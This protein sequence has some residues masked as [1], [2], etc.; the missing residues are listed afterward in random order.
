MRVASG[1][2]LLARGKRAS[3]QPAPALLDAGAHIVGLHVTQHSRLDPAVGEIHALL[4]VR[5]PILGIAVAVLHLGERKLHCLRIAVLGKIVDHRAARIS[6][7]QKLGDFVESLAGS[8]IPG[9]SYIV[10]GP[11][12][13]CTFA[14]DISAYVRR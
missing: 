2:N 6:K 11:G 1:Q 14:R 5:M 4:V 10:V 9:M 3:R 8:V 13:G 12:S 7:F